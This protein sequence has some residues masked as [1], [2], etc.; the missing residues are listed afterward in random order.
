[1][2]LSVALCTYN[3]QKYI[4]Q[5]LDSI[6][7]QS[8][9]V[10]EIIICDDVSTDATLELLDQ[11]QQKYPDVIK[12]FKNTINLKSNKNFQHSLSLCTG[13]YIFFADQDDIWE[14]DK[15]KKTIAVFN[16]NP[17]IEGV[18]SNAQLIDD[19]G[20]N[21]TRKTLWDSIAFYEADYEKPV[22]LFDIILK[23]GNMVTGATLCIKKEVKNILFPFPSSKNLYHD[24]WIATLL[25]HKSTLAYITENLIRYRIHAAQQ[26]G[27]DATGNEKRSRCED[28]VLLG[29][30]KT[31]NY[32]SLKLLARI[33][34]RNYLK[35]KEVALEIKERGTLDFTELRDEYLTLYL[36][37]EKEMAHANPVLFY[38][39]KVTDYFKGRRKL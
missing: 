11:Y 38:S 36:A 4:E 31:R 37:L 33:Y 18:F 9:K 30:V 39:R 1:M 10:N 25:A 21:F 12:V 22:N 23:K 24:E 13:D 34:Y 16:D 7:N 14:I 17:L 5:Q 3:G 20:Q 19:N 35:Y 8:V 6:V 2:T 32:S 29:K 28:E 15:V 26:V 27:A